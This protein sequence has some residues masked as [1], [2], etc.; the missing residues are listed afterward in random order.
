MA[1]TIQHVHAT[2]VKILYYGNRP[3]TIQ[4]EIAGNMDDIAEHAA[5][6]LVHHGFS[7]ADVFDANTGEVLMIITRA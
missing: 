3:D 1:I 7:N 5:G 6:V 2:E 4:Q